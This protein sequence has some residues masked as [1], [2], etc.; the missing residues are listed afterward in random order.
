MGARIYLPSIGRF[1]QVDPVE[2][3]VLNAYT[4]VLDPINTSDYSGKYAC[5]RIDLVCQMLFPN[6]QAVLKPA[7]P[8]LVNPTPSYGVPM[9][10]NKPKIA[11]TALVG[12]V[13]SLKTTTIAPKA[14]SLKA[15]VGGGVVGPK[16]WSWYGALGTANDYYNAGKI[17]GAGVGCYSGAI[18]TITSG[19]WGCLVGMPVMSVVV[20]GGA[21]AFGFVAGGYNKDPAEGALGGMTDMDMSY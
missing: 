21:A 9:P 10:L 14:S 5:A 12:R 19:G 16:S 1:T 8:N 2:G 7:I 15:T 13:A 6:I 4:Y 20:G 3:G 17:I 11:Q 18:I